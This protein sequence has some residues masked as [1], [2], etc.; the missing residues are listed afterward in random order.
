[1][2]PARIPVAKFAALPAM[3]RPILSPD[4]HR[5]AASSVA[6]GKTTLMLLNADVPDAPAKGLPLGK[7]TVAS[8]KWAGNQR[9]LLTIQSSQK[10]GG[11]DVAFLR[12]LAIDVDTAAAR[13]LDPKSRGIYAG[14]VLYTDPTGSWALVASQDDVFSYPSVKHVDL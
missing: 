2:V 13:V 7:T 5:I 10:I 4:G 8:L 6:D 12:L 1:T 3:H 11:E 14:D 9:L